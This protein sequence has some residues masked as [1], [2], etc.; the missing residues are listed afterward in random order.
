VYEY[1]KLIFVGNSAQGGQP[2]TRQEQNTSVNTQNK[3]FQRF[4]GRGITIG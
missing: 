4:G 2:T 1:K 3:D